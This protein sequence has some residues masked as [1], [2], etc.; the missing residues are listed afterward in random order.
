[1]TDTNQKLREA[2]QKAKDALSLALSDVDWRKDSPTQ[3]V[4][5]KAYNCARQALALPTAAPVGELDLPQLPDPTYIYHDA[6]QGEDDLFDFSES[7]AVDEGCPKCKR[8]YTADQMRA[9]AR[10]ALSAGDAVDAQRYRWLTDGK[11]GDWVWNHV[12]TEEVKGDHSYIEC[13]IDAAMR[14]G[15]P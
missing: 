10:A 9:Y 11:R 13:A 5:H 2:L 6:E 4:I 15:Q 14:K 12:L 8:L 7:G 3:P 1:M